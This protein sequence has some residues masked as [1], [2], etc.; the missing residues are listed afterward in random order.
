MEDHMISEA[1][2]GRYYPFLGRAYDQADLWDRDHE[3]DPLDDYSDEE[4][5]LF[6][7]DPEG[8]AI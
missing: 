4:L 2:E 3:G 7:T 6:A 1:A 5:S 8:T